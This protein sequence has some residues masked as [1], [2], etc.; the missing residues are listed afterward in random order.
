MG[1]ALLSP[2]RCAAG[3]G[4]ARLGSDRPH[5]LSRRRSSGRRPSSSAATA[6]SF[7]CTMYTPAPGLRPGPG[8][9]PQPDPRSV[10]CCLSVCP[11]SDVSYTLALTI[12]AQHT[13]PTLRTAKLPATLR[14][15]TPHSLVAGPETIHRLVYARRHY[16]AFAAS[17]DVRCHAILP[18]PLLLQPLEQHG[19]QHSPLLLVAALVE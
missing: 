3:W 19:I 5:S 4:K 18:A 7:P 16:L 15:A 13:P 2:S 9:D 6:R 11:Y 10:L 17:R 14:C 8:S 1:E 12:E